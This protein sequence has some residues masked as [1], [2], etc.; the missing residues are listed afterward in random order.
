MSRSLLQPRY[1]VEDDTSAINNQKE[2]QQYYYDQH[3]KPFKP[4]KAGE[5]VCVR[6]I[7]RTEDMESRCL[8][9]SCRAKELRSDHGRTGT[10]P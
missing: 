1:P 5:T 4:L 7:T 2:R 8:F 9:W 10:Y 3:A 6:L